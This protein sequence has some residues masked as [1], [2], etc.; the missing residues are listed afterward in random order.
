MGR[1]L[2][3]ERQK[4]ICDTLRCGSTYR[5]A[6]QSAGIT[7]ETLYHWLKKADNGD[8]RYTAFATA[9]RE[10]ESACAN[11]HCER[12]MRESEDGDWK[13]AAWW[14]ERRRP[15]EF[16]RQSK[17]ILDAGEQTAELILERERART[18][19]LLETLTDR[20]SGE[21]LAQL[22]AVL[23]EMGDEEQA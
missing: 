23:E 12:I 13:A 4:I 2:T 19:Q 22:V 21:A 17:H 8:E 11:I 6:A 3:P 15:D 9:V 18:R 5:D 16:G 14:L 20:L 7:R 10:A 1:L